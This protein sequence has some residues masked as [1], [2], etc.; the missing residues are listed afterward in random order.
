MIRRTLV[1]KFSTDLARILTNRAI[2]KRAA[3]RKEPIRSERLIRWSLS[4][5]LPA[6]GSMSKKKTKAAKI[7]APPGCLLND[8]DVYL[9]REGTHR[10]LWERFGA[11]YRSVG[12]EPGV[13]FTVW[14]P[15][16]KTA[17]VVGDFNGWNTA[18][19]PLQRIGK[20]SGAWSAFVPGV[21]PGALYKFHLVSKFG[22][23]TVDKA[24]PFARARG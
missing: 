16:A 6:T 9:F 5:T 13:S 15:A 14:A 8:N 20:K 1:L 12:G 21:E 4:P 3:S 11:H 19:H 17:S 22:K 18:A 10:R 24:D 7:E 23:L 2:P